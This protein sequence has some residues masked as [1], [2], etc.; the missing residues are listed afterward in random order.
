MNAPL[1]P[2]GLAA[3]AAGLLCACGTSAVDPTL[4]A[5]RGA[6]PL[7]AEFAQ[8]SLESGVPVDLLLSVAYS[9]TRF[10]QRGGKPSA[11]DGYGMMHLR[12]GSTL[13]RA[14]Q[15]SGLPVDAL[16]RDV[17]ANVRGA[18]L[19]LA[20]LAREGGIRPASLADWK[21]ALSRY[22]GLGEWGPHYAAQVLDVVAAG[23]Q[24]VDEQ[25][26]SL[27]VKAHPEARVTLVG[28]ELGQMGFE[29]RP[30]YSG[31]DWVGPSPNS[32]SRSGTAIDMVVIHTCQGG[33]SGCVGWLL[34]SAAQASAHYVV[35]STGTV[36]QL[37]EEYLKAW[38]ATCVNPRSVGIEHEGYVD[39]PD[40]WYTEA[41]YCASAKLVKS[42]CTRHGIPCDRSH[43]IGHKEANDL[44]CGP[45]HTDPG[46]GWNWTKFMS[47]VNSGCG[48]T[49][50]G[51]LLGFVYKNPTNDAASRL[52][53]VTV[54]LASGETVTT[55]ASGLYTFSVAPGSYTAT[56][57]ATGYQSASVTRTVAAGA[58]TWGSIG[59]DAA[60]T[61]AT[62][63]QYYG[64]VYEVNAANPGDMTKKLPGATVTLDTGATTTARSDP[65]DAVFK[66]EDVKVGAHTATASLTGYKTGSSTKTVVECAAPGT[67]CTTWGSIGLVKD[68]GTVVTPPKVIITT[69]ADGAILEEARVDLTGQ[70]DN[71]TDVQTVKIEWAGQ[72]VNPPIGTG[73]TFSAPVKVPPGDTTIKV[74]A[75]NSA[76]S[77]EATVTVHFKTGLCGF[78]Y[79]SAAEGGGESAR[80][81]GAT[82]ELLPS[83]DL[84]AAAIASATTASPDGTWCIDAAPGDYY[85]RVKAASHLTSVEGVTISDERRGSSNVGVPAGTDPA[86]AIEITDPVP[87]TDGKIS[88][89]GTSVTLTGNVQGMNASKV[90][91]NGTELDVSENTFTLS[92]FAISGETTIEFVAT[93]TCGETASL[94]V[95][96]V[97]QTTPAPDAGTPTKPDAGNQP[98]ANSG[99]CGCSAGGEGLTLVGLAA[100][101]AALVRRRR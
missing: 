35:S 92:G 99:A 83:G 39:D 40:R 45:G 74:T 10:S 72:S 11:L 22:S 49:G 59:L 90:T 4:S 62:T 63:G 95:T 79:E 93:G 38:H 26:L 9:E 13:E 94:T 21:P 23:A 50:T 88:T 96:V 18:A 19:V 86:P 25:G 66:F 52:S 41:M 60:A 48:G 42:I 24:G 67:S 8:A 17:R 7:V 98:V 57:T 20:E 16:K 1:R 30:D 76:G 44:Y 29:A 34:N 56:A 54:K 91:A 32:S 65:A 12:A 87:G 64:S 53:G 47:Y 101:L 75:T 6:S 100:M 15:L 68:G 33:F 97:P 85:L 82:V 61:P 70:V 3:L 78:V 37:V 71:A 81:G 58:D 5:Q 27:E 73:A 46:S 2:L 51:R 43:V 14:S 28:D 80:I 69:P 84:C 89:T 36:D 55:D 77:G 31:A